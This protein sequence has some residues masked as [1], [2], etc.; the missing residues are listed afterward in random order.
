MRWL[1]DDRPSRLHCSGFSIDGSRTD[2]AG[3]HMQ[4]NGDCLSKLHKSLAQDARLQ[5]ADRQLLPGTQHGDMR[6]AGHRIHLGDEV[7]V[8][9]CTSPKS[10]EARR[11]ESFLQIL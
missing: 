11:I 8:R 1:Y 9:Q 10:D 5:T 6:S 7:D 4:A 3:R 2:M